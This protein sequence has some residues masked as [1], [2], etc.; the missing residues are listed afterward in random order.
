MRGLSLVQIH[1][2]SAHLMPPIMALAHPNLFFRLK[3]A[4]RKHE[5]ILNKIALLKG[6]TGKVA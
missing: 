5:D 3:I 4:L 2:N 6:M 1:L